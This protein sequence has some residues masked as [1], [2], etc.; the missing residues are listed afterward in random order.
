MSEQRLDHNYPQLFLEFP[1][2]G[3]GFGKGIVGLKTFFQ[4]QNRIKGE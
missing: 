1:A 3:Q 4:V 2:T